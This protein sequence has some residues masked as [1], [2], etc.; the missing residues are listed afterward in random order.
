MF[1]FLIERSRKIRHVLDAWCLLPVCLFFGFIPLI[2]L[3]LGIGFVLLGI[4]AALRLTRYGMVLQGL[5]LVCLFGF[6]GGL[7]VL[8]N[9]AILQNQFERI[10]GHEAPVYVPSNPV[11][12]NSPYISQKPSL[13][14]S[15]PPITVPPPAQAPVKQPQ[16]VG[17]AVTCGNPPI[18]TPPPQNRNLY[19]EA[20]SLAMAWHKGRNAHQLSEIIDQCDET[21]E[22]NGKPLP[23]KERLKL[24]KAA[25]EASKDVVAPS[26]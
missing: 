25:V 5:L 13:P 26:N 2:G 12:F 19:D 20:R 24:R 8:G 18:P 4:F 3:P 9:F 7:L 14:I 6:M 23:R 17:D 16:P 11:V 22:I 10:R 1:E 21:V 15:A